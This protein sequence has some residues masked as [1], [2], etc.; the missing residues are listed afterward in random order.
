M[1]M[2]AIIRNNTVHDKW[3]NEERDL[4]LFPFKVGA[5]FDIHMVVERGYVRVCFFTRFRMNI[6]NNSYLGIG[7]WYSFDQI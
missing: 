6:N 3:Q 7:E 4:S 5:T 1:Q 2:P